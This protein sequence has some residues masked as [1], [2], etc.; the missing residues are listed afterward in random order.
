[1]GFD[2]LRYATALKHYLENRD[3]VLLAEAYALGRQAMEEGMGIGETT[4]LFH[5]SLD[6]LGRAHDAR[7]FTFLLETMAP[8]EM[9]L[10]GYRD[11]ANELRKL[12]ET[13]NAT[14]EQRTRELTLSQ[15]QLRQAQKMDSIGRLAGGIAHDFN[16]ILCVMLT[17]ASVLQTEM[18]A[19]LSARDD[20]LE[21]KRAAERGAALTRQLL[22][23]SRQQNIDTE[24]IELRAAVDATIRMI[25]RLVPKSVMLACELGDADR[26]VVT[27]RGQIEQVVMNLILN[28][29]DAIPSDGKISVALADVSLSGGD[30]RSLGL[31]DGDYVC[32][33]ISDSGCGIAPENLE[34][35]FEPFFTT[36]EVGKGTGLGLSTALGIATKNGGTIR[37]TSEVGRGATFFVYLPRQ[38]SGMSNEPARPS[39]T[40][41]PQGALLLVEDDTA[42]RQALARY[43]RECGFETFEAANGREALRVLEDSRAS[44]ALVITDVS[45]PVIGGVKLFDLVR[46]QATVLPFLFT[47]GYADE[48][49]LPKDRAVKFIQKP[50]APEEL[51]AKISEVLHFEING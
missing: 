47:S 49:V 45:M 1:M 24:T 27:G 35:I 44:V 6:K 3:E 32:L 42:L 36:K 33:Q 2:R 13:L 34:T 14:V 46:S 12:N 51:V 20:V 26:F 7:S 39:T 16:N 17:Y 11:A 25:Q 30:A 37:V 5:E 41:R 18:A 15:E 28:A 9:A 43:L 10:R 31:R 8:F 23:F 19:D 50:F 4:Q 48:Q 29:C 38:A 22:T 21:I 40:R